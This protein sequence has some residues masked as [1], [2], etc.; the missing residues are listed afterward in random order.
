MG[1]RAAVHRTIV[2]VDVEGF[3]DRHRILP[4]QLAVRGGL[5]SAL[6]EAFRVAGV[7]WTACRCEDRGDAVFVL[8]RPEVPKALFVETVPHA[9]VAAVRVHNASHCREQRIRLRMAVHAGEVAYDGHGVTSAAV[10]LTFR[11][12]DARSVKMA[13]AESVGVL[14]LITSDWFFDDVV[15]HCPAAEPT[16]YRPT[17]VEVKETVTV[18]WICLPDHAYPAD[19]S[20]LTALLPVADGGGDGRGD[21]D[22]AWSPS[23]WPGDG[24]D[25]EFT[26]PAI[27]LSA[28]V[29]DRGRVYQAGR[30]QHITEA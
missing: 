20:V 12:V 5:Y 10:N 15:R 4:H 18:G 6:Q 23:L 7:P 21:R 26:E 3:G 24:S 22:A 13:L 29:L 28:N 30:D 9:L 8:A 1:Q 14:A 11:L 27:R 2:V 19:P 25:S 17:R 16:T